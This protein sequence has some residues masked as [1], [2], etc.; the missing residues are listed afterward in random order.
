MELEL[1]KRIGRY[2]AFLQIGSG[3]M[4]RVYLGV[5]EGPFAAK[6]LVVIKQ[7]RQEVVED[8]QFL[9]L[10]IDEARIALRLNHPNVVHTY[11]VVAEDS[12]YYLAMEFLDG[13]SLL[14]V[15]RRLD[16]THVPLEEHVWILTQVLSGLHYAH[17]I[18]ANVLV[19]YTGAVKLLDFGIAKAVGALAATQEGVMRGKL[20]YAAPEQCIGKPADRRSDVY[21]VGVMLWEA[22]AQRRRTS[23]ETW[24]AMVQARVQDSEPPLEEVSPGAHPALVAITR[25]ALCRDPSSRYAT[26]LDFQRDLE[27]YLAAEPRR[28][29]AESVSAMLR[30]HF[31]QERA[32]I[33]R[34]IEAHLGISQSLPQAVPLVP[35]MSGSLPVA[36]NGNTSSSSDEEDTSRIPVD[37]ALLHATIRDSTRAPPPEE[38]ARAM[39]PVVASE[40]D[41]PA[42]GRSSLAKAFLITLAVVGAAAFG[43]LMSRI[44]DKPGSGPPLVPSGSGSAGSPAAIVIAPPK[45]E[46]PAR[47]SAPAEVRVRIAVTPVSAV[48]RLD[49]LPLEQNPFVG[50]F[51]RD[52]REHELGASAEHYQEEA[53]TLRFEQDI[54][55]KLSLSPE[56]GAR[57]GR[58]ARAARAPYTPRAPAE[59]AAAAAPVPAPARPKIEPGMDMQAPPSE[60]RKHSIDE[61]D[62][63]NP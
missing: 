32:D 51:P 60:R 38:P 14:Q 39:E 34:A 10:F 41:G 2:E 58:L 33:R 9:E 49:S 21:A 45:A 31:E 36:A 24:S 13:Q 15:L 56:H 47:P 27:R 18:K 12:E 20:G 4:A 5:Q 63:Y 53:R 42:L 59:A 25:R 8:E 62:P 26:A 17:E 28:V 23:G 1:P 22:I 46:A 7:L 40:P 29:G 50:T 30:P 55:L 54:D 52:G 37:G 16:R 44:G 3:G 48:L 35:R 11:E 19:S 57:A 43:S 6:K 61:K